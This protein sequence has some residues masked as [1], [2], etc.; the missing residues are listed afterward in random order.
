VIHQK[1]EDARRRLLDL[2]RR[3]RLLNFKPR[4][5]RSI[6]IVDERPEEVYRILVTDGKRMDFLPF[7][8][9]ET[10][11]LSSAED[12][13]E[14]SEAEAESLF[15]LAAID[16][17]GVAAER[18]SDLYLQT[19]LSGKKLQTRLLHLARDAKS[20]L[21]EQGCNVLYLAVGMLNW[22]ASDDS[23][24]ISKAPLLLVPVELTR[25]TARHRHAIRVLDD[26]AVVNPTLI[27]LCR[28]TFNLQLPKFDEGAE[29]PIATFL[30]TIEEAVS[31]MSGW[32]IEHDMYVGIFSFAKILMY[33]DLQ[34]ERWPEGAKVSEHRLVRALCGLGLED[35]VSAEGL[36][37][38]SD[39]DEKVPPSKTFQVMDADSSQQAAIVAAKRGVDLVIDGPPGTG[40]SQTITNI[41][42]ECLSEGKTVLFVAEKAAALEVVK[43]RLTEVGLGDFA[44]E[45][46]SR[47]TSK[48]DFT[49]DLGH[50][51]I[52][53]RRPP[54]DQEL[55]K[56]ADLADLR[57]KLN[58]YVRALH[59]R[60]EPLGRTPYE[61]MGTC[62]SLE[63]APEAPVELGEVIDWDKP[64]LRECEEAIGGFATAAERVG[65]AMDHPWRGA[66]L[67]DVR[68]PLKQ[69]LPEVAVALR[70]SIEE[71]H[72]RA[73]ALGDGLGTGGPENLEQALDLI[74]ALRKVL[75]GP[76]VETKSL[77]GSEWEI[78]PS[79]A[80]GLV[81]SG[82]RLV[83]LRSVL[84]PRWKESAESLDWTSVSERRQ[85]QAGSIFRFLWP[86]WRRDTR[87]I[88]HHLRERRMPAPAEIIAD[89]ATLQKVR[90][91][92][93]SLEESWGTGSRLFGR[94]WRGDQSDWDQ[95]EAYADT[96]VRLRRLC[97]HAQVAEERLACFADQ[98]DRKIID[99]LVASLADAVDEWQERWDVFSQ[100]LDLDPE[101][102]FGDPPE[103]V[104]FGAWRDRIQQCEGKVELL[105]DWVD[106][107]RERQECERVDIPSFLE[108]IDTH[109]KEYPPDTW[110]RVFSRQFH[111]IWIDAV[112]HRTPEL[113]RFRG[114][115]HQ[116]L[117][118]RFKKMDRE[119][120]ELTRKRLAAD[121]AQRRPRRSQTTSDVGMRTLQ[122]EIRRK[123]GIK[124]I[125][126][127]LASKAGPHIQ[128]LKPCF[129]MSP[130]SIAQF[131]KP[132]GLT[133]DV[134][135]FDEASQV[136]PA[137]ALGAVA[138]AEQVVLVGDDKQLPP[139][140]FFR[141][142]GMTDGEDVGEEEDESPTTADLESVLR[143]GQVCITV[144]E[145]LRWHYRSRHHS[146][147]DFSNAEF[148]ERRL[149]VFPSPCKDDEDLG[150]RFRHVPDG[151]YYRGK[152]RFNEIE[153]RA[154]AEAVVDHAH[155]MPDLT[156][157][158]AA[159]SR[160]QQA[161]IE[162]EVERLLRLPDNKFLEPF[163]ADHPN[164]PFF[165][166]NLETVQGDE[167]DV[168]LISVGY[169]PDEYGKISM[170]FGP[171]NK[172]GGWRRLNVLV[173]RARR[174]CV[175]FSS[176]TADQLRI[177]DTTPRGVVTLKNYLKY[178]ETGVLQFNEPPTGEHDSE[179]ERE[180]CQRLRGHGCEV[181]AQV[182]CAG[183]SIDMAIVDP[184]APG[185]YVV[186]IECDGATYHSSPTAR[187]RDRLRQAVLE[188]LGWKI[189]RVW[190][191][192][193][194][195]QPEKT[196]DRLLRQIQS[197]TDLVV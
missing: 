162:D 86:T 80:S 181:D 6:R 140:D 85:R 184:Q 150:L 132:G 82:R 124:P 64:R 161:A 141:S 152:G 39:L 112:M 165:V 103:S 133:F 56:A 170:N 2:S 186:G 81:L 29:T 63:N 23:R 7:E 171:I 70:E 52:Q 51:I 72:Q 61:I 73:K 35:R 42:A 67:S 192:D 97:R 197:L 40:K 195:N 180:V 125:R 38:P 66:G 58:A 114:E 1:L 128:R 147:I 89:F 169:G 104:S 175:V 177:K 172:D 10:P 59:E 189:I 183:F 92:K 71:V 129:M 37:T 15:E 158:V 88:R 101:Q 120:I 55:A 163:L 87:L 134:V 138:R 27:E 32:S 142:T 127:L 74:D 145:T 75:S 173:T 98:S 179:F 41:I 18:H 131:L 155:R 105:T 117:I 53:S 12:D 79:D 185:R 62:A 33:L 164:E 151:V 135:I 4:N 119:W 99:D 45:L 121:I 160:P 91:L 115:D 188:D 31:G 34:D 21:Q 100:S 30:A 22:V 144:R 116:R 167:R 46:H 69:Q 182:G 174:R 68:L 95:L 113:R 146:L 190:S 8:E 153:A 110:V 166:K 194:F 20:A 123:R 107:R 126:E 159:F 76:V 178:A 139:T 78:V 47:K 28:R 130:I 109:R 148:Y 96:V 168:I 111:R 77:T 44:A 90:Q 94:Y 16:D 24:I 108:W 25:R 49:D 102:F 84:A 26:E 36:P 122:A 19:A 156:L 136:E 187:D 11:G 196:L 154:V 83:E 54:C 14:I 57:A 143:V 60:I 43:R 193:W 65:S 17:T 3:N 149:R 50:V 191:T 176:I 5:R 137:D 118:E 13:E 9:A 93:D 157:G 48:K 106:Y